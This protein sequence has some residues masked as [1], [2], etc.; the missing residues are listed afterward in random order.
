MS[1]LRGQDSDDWYAK[2]PSLS[3]WQA[4]M[5]L[6]WG[7]AARQFANNMDRRHGFGFGGELLYNLQ[8][9]KPLWAGAG[10][11]SFAFDEF[12]MVYSQEI[13]GEIFNYR[14]KTVSRIFML[15]G[16]M[17]FQPE[18]RFFLQPY[19]QG[20]AGIHWFFTNTKTRDLDYDE[21]VERINENRDA[22]W[23]FSLQAGVQYVPRKLPDIRIDTRFGYY[24]NASVEYL[25]YNPGIPGG[26]YTIDYFESGISPVDLFGIHIGLT[27]VIRPIEEY[28]SDLE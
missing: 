24:R 28:L 9:R 20:A 19:L 5:D 4:S 15:H 13:D 11:H 2:E 27:A 17:R 12:S 3:R 7:I 8:D 18:V 10:A 23:G 26:N 1:G 14:D 25:W 22:I 21:Q 6:D 16:V